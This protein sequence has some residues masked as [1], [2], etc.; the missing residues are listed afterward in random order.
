MVRVHPALSSASMDE[1]GTAN[2]LWEILEAGELQRWYQSMDGVPIAS[3]P[4]LPWLD[5]SNSTASL[6]IV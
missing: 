5:G 3:M 6:G 2:P 4:T 1:P